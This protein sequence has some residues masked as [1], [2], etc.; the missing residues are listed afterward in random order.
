M[1]NNTLIVVSGGPGAGKT[2]LIEA[3]AASGYATQPEI[4]RALIEQ[5][6]QQEGDALPWRN[7][8]AFRDAMLTQ[9]IARYQQL[10]G[11]ALCFIDRSVIDVAAYSALVNLPNSQQLI[12]A[13]QH[14]RYNPTAFLLPP[15]RAIYQQD[16]ARKQ[17]FAEAERTYL[18][19]QQSYAE[20]GYRTIAVP[21]APVARRVEFVLS[22]LNQ[23]TAS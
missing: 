17:D 11:Q 22:Q 13:C 9:E 15:W 7:R 12:H 21:P 1:M 20:Y 23:L 2:T 19:L 18:Q 10:D 3:L 5:Q 8:L 16:H 6:L 4:A 14:Y